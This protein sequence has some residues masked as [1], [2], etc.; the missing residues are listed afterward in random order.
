MPVES[1]RVKIDTKK[2]PEKIRE[3]MAIAEEY[4]VKG[5]IA[6]GGDDTMSTARTLSESGFP[7]VGVA[8][9]ID[10]DISVD[11]WQD[12]TTLLHQTYGWETAC[13]AAMQRLLLLREQGRSTGRVTIGE[14]MGRK[15]SHIALVAGKA[16]GAD[17]TLIGECP[18]EKEFLFQR[19]REVLERQ[20]NV[21][22]AVAEGY[23]FEGKK[24]EGGAKDQYG[25]GHLGGI[26]SVLGDAIDEEVTY[27]RSDGQ[28]KKAKTTRQIIGYDQQMEPPTAAD[29]LRAY[30][31]G[32]HA[33][34]LAATGQFGRMATMRG[35]MTTDVELSRVHGGQNVPTELY[36][37]ETMSMQ[38]VPWHIEQGRLRI[39]GL[40]RATGV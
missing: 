31:M 11:G 19:I 27:R 29:A 34:Y 39:R 25:H 20:G 36:D 37:P 12:E 22:I 10:N 3:V 35:D 16:A 8:K 26:S 13:N 38:D 14:A 21:L 32:A 7:V 15:A 40:I 24:A 9:T 23:V 6:N 30:H 18:I 28:E 2:N 5:L 17:I 1:S 4:G 33:G